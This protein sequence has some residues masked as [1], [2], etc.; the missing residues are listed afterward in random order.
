MVNVA[1]GKKGAIVVRWLYSSDTV[2]IFRNSTKGYYTKNIDYVIK[3]FSE[4][5]EIA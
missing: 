2:I 4:S 5:V 1:I 3:A